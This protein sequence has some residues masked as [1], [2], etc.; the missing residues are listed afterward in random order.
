M[1]D[2]P[3]KELYSVLL[4]AG[5]GVSSVEIQGDREDRDL[6][7][8]PQQ[9]VVLEHPR[10]EVPLRTRL[11]F[12]VDQNELRAAIKRLELGNDI[13]LTALAAGKVDEQLCLGKLDIVESKPRFDVGVEELQEL[14]EE[15]AQELFEALVVAHIRLLSQKKDEKK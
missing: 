10:F 3:A 12:D 14:L 8:R 7:S 6:V 11:D 15:L 13:G 1:K 4:V 2:L 5:S 9:G